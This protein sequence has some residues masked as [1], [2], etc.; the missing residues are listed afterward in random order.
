MIEFVSGS[1]VAELIQHQKVID[2]TA[3]YKRAATGNLRPSPAFYAHFT[4]PHSTTR[5][6]T[7]WTTYSS[8]Q[9]GSDEHV[10]LCRAQ[11]SQQD[12]CNQYAV[13]LMLGYL[14][15]AR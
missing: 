13:S 6:N 1:H 14:D 15:Q 7:V 12:C 8:P 11:W 9:T 5:P 10:L 4:R 2:Y 3:T